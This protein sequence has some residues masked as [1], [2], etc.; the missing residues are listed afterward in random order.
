MKK[1]D[2]VV[3]TDID[4]VNRGERLEG[5]RRRRYV[6]YDA[7]LRNICLDRVGFEKE[8]LFTHRFVK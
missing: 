6:E 3:R 4:R 8:S 5:R 7:R 2:N 1:E